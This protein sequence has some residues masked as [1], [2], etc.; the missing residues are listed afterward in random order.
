MSQ[1]KLFPLNQLAI[2][3]YNIKLLKEYYTKYQ[4]SYYN[5]IV[6]IHL[7]HAQTKDTRFIPLLTIMPHIQISV[8]ECNIKKNITIMTNIIQT[9]NELTHIYEDTEKHLITIPTT[10]L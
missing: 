3:E 7:I 8:I 5:N 4:H 6:H 1:C 9:E 2:I 10:I